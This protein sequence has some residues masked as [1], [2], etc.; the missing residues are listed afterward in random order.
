[1]FNTVKKVI[2]VLKSQGPRAAVEVLRNDNLD[3]LLEDINL[4]LRFMT[5][6][7]EAPSLDRGSTRKPSGMI[8]INS[9]YGE[10]V[11]SLARNI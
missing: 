11:R 3:A 6:C 1:M 2:N 7:L 4:R 9:S 8:D 10:T 5:D